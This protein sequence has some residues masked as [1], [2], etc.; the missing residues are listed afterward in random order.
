MVQII[1]PTKIMPA[2]LSF[3]NSNPAIQGYSDAE[4]LRFRQQ[5]AQRLDD[6]EKQKTATENSIRNDPKLADLMRDPTDQGAPP[7]VAT[8]T[9]PVPPTGGLSSISSASPS[10]PPVQ[11]NDAVPVASAPASEPPIPKLQ[12]ISSAATGPS[13]WDLQP[14]SDFGPDGPGKPSPVGDFTQSAPP[15]PPATEVNPV[16]HQ[17]STVTASPPQQ[18]QSGLPTSPLSAI[19][20]NR[21]DRG[22][23][24]LNMEL[25]RATMKANP[26]QA[27]SYLQQGTQQ[28]AANWQDDN[29]RSRQILELANS[30]KVGEAA[31]LARQYGED[32]DPQVLSNGQARYAMMTGLD[33]AKAMGADHDQQWI[34]NFTKNFMQT[35]DI[36]AAMQAAGK[37]TVNPVKDR[38]KPVGTEVG[39]KSFTGSFDTATGTVTPG[40][41]ERAP[42][43]GG[44]PPREQALIEWG[45]TKGIWKD[46]K[47]GW[48]E[49]HSSVTDPNKIAALKVRTVQALMKDRPNNKDTLKAAQDAA[50]QMF[51]QAGLGAVRP[52]AAS[53]ANRQTSTLRDGREVYTDDD[54]KSVYYSDTNTPYTG[55]YE[56]E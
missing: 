39:G 50:D 12:Q 23:A 31:M 48:A 19:S 51:D 8:S 16:P 3:I 1:S 5:N 24:R 20:S 41:V 4:N 13:A 29:A 35:Q 6:A 36:N 34:A 11:A 42:T 55:D 37:P 40:T 21:P 52:V 27:V 2:G 53:P 33:V 14:S 44:R 38:F 28:H 54:G 45:M 17:P 10:P 49:V 46:A 26:T 32:I 30:G 56:G 15:I 7:D 25:A 22:P 43:D 47:T 9:A 18:S